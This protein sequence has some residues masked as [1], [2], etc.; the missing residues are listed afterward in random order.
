MPPRIPKVH[1]LR[2]SNVLPARH[3][4]TPMTLPF[5][6]FSSSTPS[7]A[8]EPVKKGGKLFRDPYIVSQARARK[9]AN[10]SRQDALAKEREQALGNAVRGETTSFVESFD[11]GR[12]PEDTTALNHFLRHDEIN[13]QLKYSKALLRPIIAK[14]S[15]L[16]T[17]A[18]QEDYA[19]QVEVKNAEYERNHENVQAA[20]ERIV[21]LDNGSSKD[22]LRS[23]IQRCIQ[24]F[25]RHE[26]DQVLPPKP[27]ATP[28]M[29]AQAMRDQ[30]TAREG[31]SDRADRGIINRVGPD[32]GSSEVQIG[33]LTAKI[34][35]LANHLDSR[36]RKDKV[37]KRDLRLL[38]HRRQKL[39]QYLKRKE[40]GGPRWQRC[41]ETLGLTEG[42]WQGE[43]SL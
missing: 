19:R 27:K 31:V 6:L 8:P 5:R 23:N 42:T 25:G 14:P 10:I 21:N 43:I 39:L 4:A 22:R 36:G 28:Q 24:H 15:N 7:Q 17:K 2:A 11:L 40:R 13:A 37:G 9:A 12:D 18:T 16:A 41:I 30:Q 33:I 38:V 26:T 20:L 32:V 3:N 1:C 34:R 35:S 29:S